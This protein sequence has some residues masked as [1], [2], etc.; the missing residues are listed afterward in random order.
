MPISSP[1]PTTGPEL[2]AMRRRQNLRRTALQAAKTV[3]VVTTVVVAA[4]APRRSLPHL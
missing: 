4:G 1:Q 3:A 2:D